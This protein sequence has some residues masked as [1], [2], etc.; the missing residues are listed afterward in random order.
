M[1]LEP[2]DPSSSLLPPPSFPPSQHHREGFDSEAIC[3]EMK[4]REA[5]ASEGDPVD[6]TTKVGPS[7]VVAQACCEVLA[8]VRERVVRYYMTWHG[9]THRPTHRPT[10]TY[11]HTHAHAHP[12]KVAHIFGR[13]ENVILLALQQLTTAVFVDSNQVS[14]GHNVPRTT[15]RTTPRISPM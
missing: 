6:P 4:L 8:Q 13:F 1:S 10:H 7:R 5:L 11:A 12:P 14:S 15:P 9:V 3:A 2:G